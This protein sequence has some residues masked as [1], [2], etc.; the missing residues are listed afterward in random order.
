MLTMIKRVP[1]RQNRQKQEI[2]PMVSYPRRTGGTDHQCMV[3]KEI[4]RILVYSHFYR[5]FYHL[6]GLFHTKV[7]ELKVKPGIYKLFIRQSLFGH[8]ANEDK[9]YNV[10]HIKEQLVII[11][12]S[13]AILR[14]F[15][16]WAILTRSS[17]IQKIGN[18]TTSTH[19][20][21]RSW[22]CNRP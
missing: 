17:I 11:V 8:F 5:M 22:C 6:F 10:L 16:H 19:I 3:E 1:A 18:P 20:T 15:F 21:F 4:A 12:W 2:K 9:I 13:A 7:H 14:I